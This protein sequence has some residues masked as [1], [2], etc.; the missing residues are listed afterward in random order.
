M[1]R[2]QFFLSTVDEQAHLLARQYGLGIELAEFC[3]P[4][5][6]DREFARV[7][8][9]VREKIQGIENRVLHG[10]FS[11]VFPCA[12]DPMVRQ[13][14]AERCRQTIQA[15]KR[16][17][18][19]KI[20]L[21][22][23]YNPRIYYP[24]WYTEQSVIFWREFLQEVPAGMVLCLENVFEEEPGMILDI[25]RQVDDPR[26]RMCLD[27]G[28]VN[29][30]SSIPVQEWLEQCAPWISHFHIHNNDASRDSHNPLME[31]SIPMRELLKQTDSLCPEAT[32][33]LELTE[34]QSSVHW[35][36]EELQ[37]IR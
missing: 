25:L 5:N 27:V 12:I 3:T 18:I 14:A 1:K 37:W 21:H 26:L 22:G 36:L 23:G 34:A 10:P 24:I 13:V 29:A 35:L 17:G 33:T 32:I 31:G 2:Q 6:L 8:G 15:A 19:T 4:W 11:E 28:H 20:I 16:Y 7:D 9:E 30:Y